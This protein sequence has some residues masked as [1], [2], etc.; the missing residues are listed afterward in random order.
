[1]IIKLVIV[2]ITN[3]KEDRICISGYDINNNRFLRPLLPHSHIT[4]DFLTRFNESIHLGSLVNIE[5]VSS[6]KIN[7]KPHCEDVEINP[8]SVKVIGKMV[9]RKYKEF[10]I[11]ISDDSIEGIY[12]EDLELLNGQPV[13]PEDSGVRSLGVIVCRK[14]SV[15]HNHLGRTRCG[16][17]DKSGAEY[18]NI[19]VV[20]R[21]EWARPLGEFVNVPLRMGLSRLWKKEGM[22]ESFYWVHVSAIVV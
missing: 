10:L 17:T 5:L 4:T 18:R 19:P 15:Y 9:Q 7:N 21:D 1:M 16:V 13:L 12:G 3:M 14:C 11:S 20:S 2:G 22:E 6:P 8:D